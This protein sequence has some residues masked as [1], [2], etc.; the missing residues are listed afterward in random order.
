[1]LPHEAERL[2]APLGS[3]AGSAHPGPQKTSSDPSCSSGRAHHPLIDITPCPKQ[4]AGALGASF[5]RF[6]HV[7]WACLESNPKKAGIFEKFFQS[8]KEQKVKSEAE[9][10][11][12]V[13]ETP[14]CFP[15]R[16]DQ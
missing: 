14:T 11:K 16:G 7:S 10:E 5:L 6:G 4:R 15:L 1:M 8:P 13:T 9:R 3:S 12:G 2:Q